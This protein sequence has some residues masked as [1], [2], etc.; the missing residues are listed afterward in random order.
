MSKIVSGLLLLDRKDAQILAIALRF[1]KI[2]NV[3]EC[4]EGSPLLLAQLDA[5]A[6]D[7]NMKTGPAQ[8]PDR[9]D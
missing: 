7:P 4:S 9:Q 6:V 8:A 5:V 1:A 2:G 3:M